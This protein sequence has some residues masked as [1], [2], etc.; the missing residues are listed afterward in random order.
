M[1]Q[2]AATG[3]PGDA[4]KLEQSF[5]QMLT[6]QDAFGIMNLVQSRNH[7]DTEGNLSPRDFYEGFKAWYT[8]Q[9]RP[10]I[11]TLPPSDSASAKEWVF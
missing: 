11:A 9:G 3:R 6:S 10:E 7:M 1:I 4:V 2:D 5:Q 8:A